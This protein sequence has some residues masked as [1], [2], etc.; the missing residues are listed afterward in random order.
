MLFAGYKSGNLAVWQLEEFTFN[1][2]AVIKF[3]NDSIN[4]LVLF[5]NNYLLS[6]SS[7]TTVKI[8]DLINDKI[9]DISIGVKIVR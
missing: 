6:C 7:D 1:M 9:Q 5:K 4:R 2:L 3:H 8:Y